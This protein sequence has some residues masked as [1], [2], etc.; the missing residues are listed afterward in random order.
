MHSGF[1][2]LIFED[3]QHG[4]HLYTAVI[5][6]LLHIEEVSLGLVAALWDAADPNVFLLSD[7]QMLYTY[8][9]LP[10]FLQGTGKA[11]VI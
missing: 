5:D 11:Q 10:N 8:L 9:Y 6:Q 2:R 4:V 7:G 3:E 1:P